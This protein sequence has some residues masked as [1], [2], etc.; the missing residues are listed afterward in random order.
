[1][2]R[3]PSITKCTD[4]YKKALNNLLRKKDYHTASPIKKNKMLVEEYMRLRKENT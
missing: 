4:L 3:T 1:M 2:N